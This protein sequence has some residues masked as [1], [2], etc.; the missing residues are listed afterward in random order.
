MLPSVVQDRLDALIG[1]GELPLPLLPEAAAQVLALVRKP[2]CDARR[3]AELVKRDPAMTAH[4]MQVASSPLYGAATKI[5]SVP[6]AIARLGFQQVTQ[7]ALAVASKARVFRATGFEAEV[8][9]A[10]QHALTAALFAQE[11]A[12]ARRSAVDAAF[13]AGLFHDFGQPLLMQAIVDLAA[14]AGVAIDRAAVFAAVDA[15]HAEVGAA[16]VDAWGMPPKVAEAV[17]VHH[18]PG[19][20]ELATLVA[21][22][23]WFAHGAATPMPTT[24]AAALNLYPDDVAGIAKQ[25]EAIAAVVAVVA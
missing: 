7:V 19:G 9:L 21:F 1:T 3:L 6:Q 10:F 14:D 11:I 23:D 15:R 13:L 12:R 25:A 17:K 22:A 20:C 8:K 4:V 18:E 2:D 5:A 24:H 16:L